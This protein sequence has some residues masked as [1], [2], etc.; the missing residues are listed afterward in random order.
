MTSR[1]STVISDP[2]LIASIAG[3]PGLAGAYLAYR[4]SIKAAEKSSRAETLKVEA[5]AYERARQL[6]ED[7]IKQLEEQVRRMRQQI[8]DEQ[9]VSSGLRQQIN[10]L[11]LTV[12][13]L[14]R[15]LINAGIELAPR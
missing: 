10:E 4:Q 14:R 11:E 9:A 5:G 8:S 1:R 2:V 12:S 13:S 3:V 15:Q 7:G 6:Y